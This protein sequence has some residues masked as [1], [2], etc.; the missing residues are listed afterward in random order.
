MDSALSMLIEATAHINAS[1]AEERLSSIQ[2]LV[3]SV[4]RLTSLSP[5]E[6]VALLTEAH[7]NVQELKRR[8][9]AATAEYEEAR[10]WLKVLEG[11]VRAQDVSRPAVASAPA[12]DDPASR[13]T[14]TVLAEKPDVSRIAE[15]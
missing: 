3:E 14:A 4:N 7:E 9:E 12:I 6:Q 13:T 8:V 10:L 11:V 2:T 1:S 5:Q 15:K